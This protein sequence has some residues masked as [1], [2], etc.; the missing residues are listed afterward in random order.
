MIT[1]FY[2]FPF[3]VWQNFFVLLP[4]EQNIELTQIQARVM[5]EG[6]LKHAMVI[7]EKK[8]VQI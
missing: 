1:L 7:M 4:V 6:C 2:L 8:Q 5:E 3:Y